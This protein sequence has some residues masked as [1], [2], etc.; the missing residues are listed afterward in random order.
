MS[1]DKHMF[2]EKR[3]DMDEF[4]EFHAKVPN[5]PHHTVIQLLQFISYCR[6]LSPPCQQNMP[7]P[8]KEIKRV[9]IQI[10]IRNRTARVDT[11]EL[12]RLKASLRNLLLQSTSNF[13]CHMLLVFLQVSLTGL[14]QL[15]QLSKQQSKFDP[16]CEASLHQWCEN[17][18]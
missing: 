7:N 14:G 10:P 1:F 13:G 9:S 12:K 16:I 15:G 6:I 4:W 5:L 17:R 2:V 8:Q 11:G 18:T 3:D